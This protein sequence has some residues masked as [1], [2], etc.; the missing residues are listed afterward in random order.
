MARTGGKGCAYWELVGKPDRKLPLG[1]SVGGQENNKK[2]DIEQI[3]WEV[4]DW[5]DVA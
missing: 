5:I 1:G 2:T 3:R 4:M